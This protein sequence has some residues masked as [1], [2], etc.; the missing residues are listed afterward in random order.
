MVQRN[1]TRTSSPRPTSSSAGR[2]TNRKPSSSS[3]APYARGERQER[4]TSSSPYNREDRPKRPVSSSPYNREEKPLKPSRTP[5]SQ[6]RSYDS[7][8]GSFSSYRSEGKNTDSKRSAATGKINFGNKKSVFISKEKRAELDQ[9][10]KAEAQ[11]TETQ[12]TRHNSYE[13][14]YEDRMRASSQLSKDRIERTYSR[15]R[16]SHRATS[17]LISKKDDRDGVRLNKFIAHSGVCS[18][19]DADMYIRSG[20][21]QVNDKIVT[22]MGYKVLPTDVVRFDGTELKT[23][24]KVYVLL[25]KPKN[26][27]TTTD[28]PE[29]RKTVME[30]VK[31]ATKE[32]IYPV[33]RLDRSTM[34][35]LLFT[36]DGE[37]AKGIMHPSSNIKK[38]YQVTLDRNLTPNDMGRIR[39]GLE[40]EDGVIVVDNISFIP[41]ASHKE[42]GVELHCGRNRIV[43]RIFE[44]L[45]YDVVKLDRVQLGPLTKKNLSRGQWRTLTQSEIN[46]LK[47]LCGAKK[48]SY[49]ENEEDFGL[50]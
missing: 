21:V 5:F 28:D 9:Q 19:R 32:R 34:G 16:P 50:E 25:N 37:M 24:K 6:T 13:G 10:A 4:N 33:G 31:N 22:E 15:P 20:S 29:N 38:T 48:G 42:L 41:D 11:R 47:M 45:G 12:Q 39:E 18:R 27:I 44:H 14:R 3:Q 43:R 46:M 49:N 17:T 23:E 26:Y 35:L 7:K 2:Q 8:K 30:L 1:N 36:N 40:L